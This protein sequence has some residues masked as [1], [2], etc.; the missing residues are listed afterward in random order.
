MNPNDTI[1]DDGIPVAVL[2]EWL[3]RDTLTDPEE[4]GA[5]DFEDNFPTEAA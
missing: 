1:P 5:H 4:A 3:S 2:S